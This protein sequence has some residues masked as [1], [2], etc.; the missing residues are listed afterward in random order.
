ML[1]VC[2]RDALEK[3]Y[4]LD[5]STDTV[6]DLFILLS[7]DFMMPVDQLAVRY[8][9]RPYWTFD[10]ASCPLKDMLHTF[11]QISP[12]S[13]ATTTA[14]VPLTMVL[15]VSDRETA[16]KLNSAAKRIEQLFSNSKNSASSAL[17]AVRTTTTTAERGKPVRTLSNTSGAGPIA[18]TTTPG[19]DGAT[20]PSP[21]FMDENE[22]FQ[23]RLYESIQRQNI[24]ENF[25]T[26]FERT[27]EAFTSVHMLYITCSINGVP[28]K[29]FVD[30]GAQ[31]S[32]MNVETATRCN[33]LRLVDKRM[34]GTALGVGQQVII[35][36][37][38]LVEVELGDG[39]V[40]A[41]FSF[42]VLQEQVVNV[43]LG[44]DQLRRHQCCIDLQHNCLRFT[45]YDVAIP[46]L[47]EYQLT[48]E[49]QALTAKREAPVEKE[50]D[51]TT[52]DTT[53]T[54][55]PPP[56]TVLPSEEMVGAKHARHTP[57]ASQGLP[58]SQ[59]PPP[60]P[61]AT[62][63]GNGSP[64][65]S[66]RKDERNGPP[67]STKREDRHQQTPPAHPT[68]SSATEGTASAVRKDPNQNWNAPPTAT[69]TSSSPT[70]E[71]K[72]MKD[73]VPP[74]PA[75][76][77]SSSAFEA[78]PLSEEQRKKVT[79]VQEFTGVDA[80]QAFTFLDMAEWNVEVAVSLITE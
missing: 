66:T 2:R 74:V 53:T 45:Q 43:I 5:P 37:I 14:T 56:P 60:F 7:I 55:P 57:P 38:H 79:Q 26:A 30:S 36:R 50:A 46:F 80:R 13:G 16:E 54:T 63:V 8:N 78:T 27:P 49:M 4:T 10:K 72:P 68:S 48:E 64:P 15:Q 69:S 28:V 76:A 34:Q 9:R 39:H 71:M 23:H 20:A 70:Q 31:Q 17:G 52:K 29:A 47:H 6:E 62:R 40:Q 44:L 51:G 67:G 24:E 35:G 19:V 12:G 65:P 42:S 18:T 59:S 41:P 11:L 33:L 73:V 32:F 21:T 58:A 75:A 25:R 22:E 77:M 61:T 1:F 3:E